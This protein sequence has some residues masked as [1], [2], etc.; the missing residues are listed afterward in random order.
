MQSQEK[1][2]Y[3]QL[4]M[5][6]VVMPQ[7]NQQRILGR[8]QKGVQ[9]MVKTCLGACRKHKEPTRPCRCVEKVI[10][11]SGT[12][13]LD[14]RPKK[15]IAHFFILSLGDLD[16]PTQRLLPPDRL[17]LLVVEKSMT[18][19][20]FGLL[21]LESVSSWPT[22]RRFTT[23]LVVEVSWISVGPCEVIMS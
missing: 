11:L 3:A 21:L 18:L 13:I 1:D 6:E 16:L 5:P 2:V 23:L 14:V 10:C 4:H 7:R 19:L 22:V 9:V 12:W 15:S 17:E 8:K 20:W